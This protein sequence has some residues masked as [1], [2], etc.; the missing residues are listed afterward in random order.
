MDLMVT[1]RSERT[2]IEGVNPWRLRVMIRVHA[3]PLDGKAN[4][5]IEIYLNRLFGVP[6]SI[7]SGQTTRMKTVHISLHLEDVLKKLEDLK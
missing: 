6:V 3:P 4:K 2:G 5:E 7:I 1:T